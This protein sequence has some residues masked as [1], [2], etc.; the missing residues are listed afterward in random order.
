MKT[1]K[2]FMFILICCMAFVV[3]ACGEKNHTLKCEIQSE[4]TT[5]KYTIEFNK[6]ETKINKTSVEVVVELKGLEEDQLNKLKEFTEQSCVESERTN[7]KVEL[8][9]NILTNSYETKEFEIT[10][11]SEVSINALKDQLE[12]DGYTCS[13]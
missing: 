6:D 3:S 1:K 7:C 12:E 8:K 2:A 13:K 5:T 11:N 10:D 4:T 9:G